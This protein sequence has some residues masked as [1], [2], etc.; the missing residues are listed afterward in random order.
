MG[1][2][3]ETPYVV[4][5]GSGLAVHSSDGQ[6]NAVEQ[7]MR[8]GRTTG[9]ID[10]HRQHLIDSAKGSI[11]LAKNAAAAPACAHGYYQ[12]RLRHGVVGL[13]QGQFHIA[14]DR[15]GDQQHVSMSRRGHEMDTETFD[16]INGAVEA[17]NL[18]LAAVARTSIDFANVQGTARSEERR[19]G[20]ECR[21]R[22]SPYH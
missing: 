13:S 7:R 14:R 16:V 2:T 3:S 21:S 11:V 6:E 10:I 12:S 9:N 17:G 1:I 4:S 20:K 19:V 8:I 5:Y 15:T 22:W 18:H